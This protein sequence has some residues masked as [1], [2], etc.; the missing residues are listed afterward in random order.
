MIPSQTPSAVAAP[1]PCG[2][3]AATLPQGLA[4]RAVILEDGSRHEVGTVFPAPVYTRGGV[5]YGGGRSGSGCCGG[6]TPPGV[7]MVGGQWVEAGSEASYGGYDASGR[8]AQ[9]T[10]YYVQPQAVPTEGY[11]GR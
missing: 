8:Y 7:R 4:V 6:R 2:Q 10:G 9:P 3:P 11:Y 1:C 5:V